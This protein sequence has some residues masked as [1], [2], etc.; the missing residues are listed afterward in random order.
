MAASRC[1][2][3]L[4]QT[5]RAQS[6]PGSPQARIAEASEAEDIIFQVE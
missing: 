2:L 1:D 5:C 3:L 4:G 6:L